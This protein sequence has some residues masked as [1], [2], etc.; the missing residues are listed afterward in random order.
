MGESILAWS[1]GGAICEV[2]TPLWW[3]EALAR[4]WPRICQQAQPLACVSASQERQVEVYPLQAPGEGYF[5][6]LIDAV[7]A[8][9]MWVRDQDGYQDFLSSPDRAWLPRLG[10]ATAD[11]AA[12]AE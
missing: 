12:W 3:D 2:E 7:A 11:G 10:K 4:L 6:L 9:P 5:V 1:G 8:A